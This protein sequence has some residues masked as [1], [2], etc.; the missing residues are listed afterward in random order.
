MT[1]VKCDGGIRRSVI[2]WTTRSSDVI[3]GEATRIELEIECS[4]VPKQWRRRMDDV[5]C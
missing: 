4:K 1:H 5:H 2:D 3:E